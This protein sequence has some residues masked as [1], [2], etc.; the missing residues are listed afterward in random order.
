M[1]SSMK[2][3]SAEVHTCPALRKAANIPPRAA[4]SSLASPST[5]NG[6][7]PPSSSRSFLIRGAARAGAGERDHVGARMLDQA[8]RPAAGGGDH[9]EQTRR[10]VVEHRPELEG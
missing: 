5:M 1:G 6:S 7:E 10:Q 2:N 8:C 9:V 3:R 4:T